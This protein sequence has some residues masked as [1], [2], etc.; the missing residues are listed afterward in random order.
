[1]HL[2]SCNLESSPARPSR[3]LLTWALLGEGEEEE[4]EEEEEGYYVLQ[5]T[6]A[7]KAEDEDGE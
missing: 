5:D 2:G 3:S 4:E 6:A 1:M 7:A